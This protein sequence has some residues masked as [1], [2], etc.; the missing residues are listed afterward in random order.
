M[1][2]T[3]KRYRAYRITLL[4]IVIALVLQYVLG[5]FVNLYVQFPDSLPGGNAFAWV[6]THSVLI[7]AHIYLGTLLLILPLITLGLSFTL[8]DVRRVL[9]SLAGFLLL[10]LSYAGGMLFMSN[11]QESAPSMWMAIGM[12]AALV[13]YGFEFYLTRL[14][15]YKE[16]V[17]IEA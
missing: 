8:R 11:V 17:A 10:F 16:R 12:I 9:M 7:Q 4:T 14:S 6:F 5:M 1:I 2:Q 3:S 15:A 13:V